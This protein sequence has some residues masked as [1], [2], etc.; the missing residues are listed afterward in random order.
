MNQSTIGVDGPHR[1]D[2]RDTATIT[3]IVKD[4]NG[5][6]VTG[7]T[8]WIVSSGDDNTI[9]GSPGTSNADGTTTFTMTSTKP[10]VKIIAALVGDSHDTAWLPTTAMSDFT[11]SS[12]GGAIFADTNRDGA[13]QVGESG[14]AGVQVSLFQVMT[15]STLLKQTVTAGDGSYRFD[16]LASGVYRVVQTPLDQYAFSD[17][18]ALTVTVGDY[19]SSMNNDF[20]DHPT[21]ANVNGQVSGNPGGNNAL[22]LPNV[23][24]DASDATGGSVVSATTDVSGHYSLS[25]PAPLPA[26]P[27]NYVFNQGVKGAMPLQGLATGIVANNDFTRGLALLPPA[28]YPD[29]YNFSHGL[30]ALITTTYPDNYNF[31]HGLTPLDPSTYPFNYN[32]N[33]GNLTGWTPSDAHLVRVQQ[34]GESLDGSPYLYLGGPNQSATS[35]AVTVPADAQ[36]LRFAYHLLVPGQGDG[37]AG[38]FVDILSGPAYTTTTTLD[39][40]TRTWNNGWQTGVLDLQAFRGQTVRL[41]LRTLDDGH[42]DIA[43]VDNVYIVPASTAHY[44]IAQTVPNGFVASSPYTSSVDVSSGQTVQVNF[45]DVATSATSVPTPAQTSLPTVTNTPVPTVTGTYTATPT[46]APTV[47]PTLTSTGVPTTTPPTGA[48]TVT[49]TLSD[50]ATVIA[51]P[52]I[53]STLTIA[54]QIMFER[55]RPLCARGSRP[56]S[57]ILYLNIYSTTT[58]V[59]T[60]TP[61]VTPTPTDTGA[62]TDTG[63]P[64]DTPTITPTPTQTGTPT[65]TPTPTSTAL[66]GP[67]IISGVTTDR[68]V[69]TSPSY[70]APGQSVV[71]SATVVDSYGNPAADAT[72]TGTV[73]LNLPSTPV[74][75]NLV[76]SNGGSGDVYT[77]TVGGDAT[78][79][80]GFYVVSVWAARPGVGASVYPAYGSFAVSQ[81]TL[82]LAGQVTFPAHVYRGDSAVVHGC[83]VFNQSFAPDS[84][85]VALT[86]DAISGTATVTQT[87]PGIPA[88]GT[89]CFNLALDTSPLDP[90]VYTL[91]LRLQDLPPGQDPSAPT[92]EVQRLTVDAPLPSMRVTPNPLSIFVSAGHDA[93]TPVTVTDSSPLAPLADIS[94]TFSTGDQGSGAKLIPWLA[95]SPVRSESGVSVAALVASPPADVAPGAYQTYLVIAAANAAPQYIPVTVVVDSGQHGVLDVIAADGGTNQAIPDATVQLTEQVAPFGQ[96]QRTTG[97]HGEAAFAA[98]VGIVY[99]YQVTAPG[100][101]ASTGFVTLDAPVTQTVPVS[102]SLVPPHAQWNVTPITISDGYQT[103]L[104]LTYETDLPTPNLVMVPQYFQFDAAHPHQAGTL[105]VYNPSRIAV[106]GVA[107]DGTSI[108]GVQF[109]LTY[110]Y[111][112]S[113]GAP[114]TLSGTSLTIPE[115]PAG[116][117]AEIRYV[118]DATCPSGTNS[119]SGR[120]TA[121][122]YYLYFPNVPSM[123][124]NI[125]HAQGLAGTTAED[126]TIGRTLQNTGY[127][128]MTGIKVNATGTMDVDVPHDATALLDLNPS[129]SEPLPLTLHTKGLAPGS[130]ASVVTIVAGNGTPTSTLAF[131]ATVSSD[132]RVAV[133]YDFAPG[134]QEASSAD[135]STSAVVTDESCV[136]PPPPPPSPPSISSGPGGLS[137]SYGGGGTSGGIPPLPGIPVPPPPAPSAH[138]V[139]QL[140]IPQTTTLERQAFDANLQLTNI[141]RDEL[142]GVDVTLN[143]LD[144]NGSPRDATGALYADEFAI[145]R[146]HTTGYAPGPNLGTI[147]GGATATNDWTLVPGPGL[148]GDSG[149]QYSV[150]ATYHYTINGGLVTFTT[151]PV[152]ITVDP[153]PQLQISYTIPRNV[154]AFQPFKIGV[155]VKNVGAGTARNL[156]IESGQ[157]VITDNQSGAALNFA[158][159]GAALDGS[160]VALPSNALTLPFGDV[161][162]GQT[163]AGYFTMVT[164]SDGT[165]TAFDATTQE[166]PFDGVQLSP[167]IQSVRTYIVTHDGVA[168]CSG[169]QAGLPPATVQVASIDVANPRG[170]PALSN[171]VLDLTSGSVQSL[172]PTTATISQRATPAAPVTIASVGPVSGTLLAMVRDALPPTG[173]PSGVVVEVSAEDDAGTRVLPTQSYWQEFGEVFILDTPTGA[174]TYT[175]TYGVSSASVVRSGLHPRISALALADEVCGNKPQSQPELKADPATL[176]AD[177]RTPAKVTLF[178]ADAGHR[179]RL[180]SSRGSVD[181]FT[182]AF[183]VTND[184]G[185]FAA[186]LTSSTGGD[187]VVTAQDLTTGQTFDTSAEVSFVK[188]DAPPPVVSR[189]QIAIA[190][191]K[192]DCAAYVVSCPKRGFFMLGLPGLELPLQVFTDWNNLPHGVIDVSIDGHRIDSIPSPGDV[193]HYRLDINKYLTAGAHMLTL[194]ARSGKTESKPINLDLDGYRLPQWIVDGLGGLPVLED[195]NLVLNVKLPPKPLCERDS[196]ESDCKSIP[197]GLPGAPS[198]FGWATEIRMSLPTR[199]GPFKVDVSPGAESV[200]GQGSGDGSGTTPK[201]SL[202]LLGQSL[203]FDYGGELDGV[204]GPNPPYV[205]PQDLD[206][207][208]SANDELKAEFGLVEALNAFAPEGTGIA[209]ALNGSPPLH[210]W[211]DDRANIYATLTPDLNG[212]FVLSFEDGGVHV[213]KVQLGLGLSLELGVLV[214]LYV[215]EARVYAAVKGEGTFGYDDASIGLASAELAGTFGFDYRIG[216][217]AGGQ[218]GTACLRYPQTNA[219]CDPAVTHTLLRRVPSLPLIGHVTTGGY[220]LFHAHY[221]TRQAFAHRPTTE[222]RVVGQVTNMVEHSAATAVA[223]TT[224]SLL[225]SNVYTYTEPSL[226]VDSSTGHALLSWVYDDSTKPVGQ[227]LGLHFSRWDGTAWSTP[228]ALTDGPQLDG[229]PQVSWT[230]GGKAVAVWQRLDATLP[231]TATWDTHTANRMEIA[232]A[233]YDEATD[234]W[235]PVS[236]LTNNSALDMTPRLVRDP[237]GALLAIW[238]QNADGLISGDTEHPDRI[239]VAFYHNNTWSTPTTAVDGI[240]GLLDLAAGYGHNAATIAYTYP[241]TPSGSVT[242]TLELFTATWDGTAWSTPIQRTTDPL[243]QRSPQVAYNAANQPLVIWRGGDQLRLRNLSTGREATLNLPASISSLNEFQIVQDK[244]GNIAAVFT[245]QATHQNLFVSY[246]DEA[247]NLW[248]NPAQL[249]ND[250]ADAEYPTV[251]LDN[252]GRLLAAYASTAIAPVTATTVI[253]G[254]NVVTYTVPTQGQTDLLTLSHAFVKDLTLHDTDLAL[255]NDHPAPDQSVV[256]SAT[257]HNTGDLPLDDVAV[258]FYDGDPVAGGALI[259]TDILTTTLAGGFTATLTMPYTP[260]AT[261]GAHTIYAVADPVNSL[262]KADKTDTTARITAFGP[263]LRVLDAAVD[264]WGGSAVGLETLIRNIGTSVAPTSTLSFYADAVT[265]TLEVT[266]TVPTLA[267]GQVVTLT[268]PWDY[269]TL[270][271]GTHQLVAAVD[272]SA[273]PG[274]STGVSVYTATLTVAPDLSVNPYELSASSLPGGR[275]AITATVHNIGSVT[276]PPTDIAVYVDTPFS[277]TT[278]VATGTL[279]SLTPAGTTTFTATWDNPTP[280]DHTFYVAVDQARTTMETSYADKLASVV[281]SPTIDGLAGTPTATSGAG[282][283]TATPAVTGMA[284]ATGTPPTT[285]VAGTPPPTTTGTVT[286]D[287][288]PA[289]DTPTPTSTATTG[290]ATPTSS[291]TPAATSTPTTMTP[292]PTPTSTVAPI[293]TPTAAATSTPESTRTPA[294]TPTSQDVTSLTF[295]TIRGSQLWATRALSV[296]VTNIGPSVLKNV[297]VVLGPITQRSGV[298]VTVRNSDLPISATSAGG[299]IYTDTQK[300]PLVPGAQSV[301]RQWL[302]SNPSNAHFTFT[303]DVQIKNKTPRPAAT[304]TERPISL[305]HYLTS[306]STVYAVVMPAA[307]SARGRGASSRIARTTRHMAETFVVDVPGNGRPVVVMRKA[308]NTTSA[309]NR[310]TSTSIKASAR[311]VRP[312]LLQAANATNTAPQVFSYGPVYFGD[313]IAWADTNGYTKRRLSTQRLHDHTAKKN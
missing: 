270:P 66:P 233:T 295:L 170:D 55:N 143:I 182:P 197:F 134:N 19:A 34:D 87:V 68:N 294:P 304:R 282:T 297:S 241:I 78:T 290:A 62:P 249:T 310:S 91:T 214:D 263:D 8:V 292:T 112:N 81:R 125:A 168:V 9:T 160:P 70:Y 104:Q 185:Q 187:T 264:P 11:G 65:Q 283:P 301:A 220:D 155:I 201:A 196:P 63:T 194:V 169:G 35:T 258:G 39:E 140:T 209:G 122:G 309:T 136:V 129:E 248:G 51:T 221:G 46:Y 12:I 251:G 117:H 116:G 210:Q 275:V 180:V 53:T 158:L 5:H 216:P 123:A 274:A 77:A 184:A 299:F 244:I 26:A 308:A 24:V 172:T 271:A 36:S 313:I 153:L 300:A 255:S 200:D 157:P 151:A 161:G 33:I 38:L 183:G 272:R 52:T 124:L 230:G 56:W 120:L 148:G 146:P 312:P 234:T 285:V 296:S 6:G 101:N 150:S 20:A 250:P 159:T 79:A 7:K 288:T 217:F 204:L 240:P 30:T 206:I 47:T 144:Q 293:G 305:K 256:V 152:A 179:V 267:P 57:L 212:H 71:V 80:Q 131:T 227:S 105:S 48:S 76:F 49:P 215:V 29:N 302:F 252:S 175:I 188:P 259:G 213:K 177:G 115:I 18:G 203:N 277:D 287:A 90:G 102:M 281:F 42:G 121:T 89:G 193:L 107:V 73:N 173:S 198:S 98:S 268:T 37:V 280:G 239:M 132:G 84:A 260:P 226:A 176:L 67:P 229:A 167:L 111:S 43:R 69:D 83:G 128:T 28:T 130:Y 307:I 10:E 27:D 208:A 50:T 245:A 64:T 298:P 235:S 163:K 178:R 278:T 191:V 96:S 189:G 199:G 60:G 95:L 211:V 142:Q 202:V 23:V 207:H 253:S 291:D 45:T 86:A 165:F 1:A 147:A 25:L 108:P 149:R 276:S 99:Q 41:R 303:I 126:L 231:T 3:V 114:V 156:R 154:S 85:T 17:T 93:Q 54:R 289:I 106:H 59:T 92:V 72:I 100:Y 127:S 195:Q 94:A 32:F 242:P 247:H 103:T 31:T 119:P 145:T 261:G 58:A 190:D 141:T 82:S 311:P 186:N 13:R 254:G 225:A 4:G 279:P 15:S 137:I 306:Y 88:R 284:T 22:P 166:E 223:T 266:D 21:D 192:G 61:M 219:P 218:S 110:T 205:I 237:T 265:G 238:R 139:V 135:V 228:A 262:H 113:V 164:D 224:T 243:G 286:P 118:A 2:G 14:L 138:E 16:D 222:Q 174:V 162:P 246:Y 97:T 75:A 44:T 236:L 74:L 181:T 257:V 171:S 273:F 40:V 269:G 109:N 232:T 133:D